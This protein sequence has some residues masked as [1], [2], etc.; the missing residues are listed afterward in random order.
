MGV[1]F[2]GSEVPRKL[3]KGLAFELIFKGTMKQIIL[4]F[5][6]LFPLLFGWLQVPE[7][8][9]TFYHFR[10]QPQEETQGEILRRE[11]THDMGLVGKSESILYV[12]SYEHEGRSLLG[13]AYQTFARDKS[14]GQGLQL[15]QAVKV[16]YLSNK[17][18][19]SRLEVARSAPHGWWP[20]GAFT[21]GMLLIGL[22]F[23][24]LF[25]VSSLRRDR[26]FLQ[27][28]HAA[29]GRVKSVVQEGSGK[30]TRYKV[31][32]EHGEN[33]KSFELQM[34]PP[35]DGQ[36]QLL[37]VT[38][39]GEFLPECCLEPQLS[40]DD[41]DRLLWTPDYNYWVFPVFVLLANAGGFIYAAWGILEQF[42]AR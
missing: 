17:P 15:G 23:F 20:E 5:V 24:S 35:T 8:D 39:S 32:V 38:D 31:V 2:L 21:F 4:L 6:L 33:F 14:E 25:F 36:E 1:V 42:S 28:G 16:T 10:S 3:P 11:E 40:Q 7:L 26:R 37:L 18:E 13:K 34:N 9:Y 27:M 22:P 29:K 30:N 41:I 12:Y 19:I